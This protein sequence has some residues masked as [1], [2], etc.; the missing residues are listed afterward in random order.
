M[1]LQKE[2]SIRAKSRGFHLITDDISHALPEIGHI[3]IGLL[4][5]LSSTHQHH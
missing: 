1:W 3:E 4:H 2:F 5:L